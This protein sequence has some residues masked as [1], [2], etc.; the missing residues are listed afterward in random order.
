[1]MNRLVF[2]SGIWLA[3]FVSVNFASLDNIFSHETDLDKLLQM[4]NITVPN[5]DNSTVPNATTVSTTN[6]TETSTSPP[7]YTGKPNE[8]AAPQ[9]LCYISY[10]M[11]DNNLHQYIV[12]DAEELTRSELIRDPTVT[13][14]LYSDGS[15]LGDEIQGVLN[16]DGTPAAEDDGVRYM[17]WDHEKDS[18]VLDDTLGEL[19]SDN[20]NSHEEFL[21]AA[22][23]DCVSKGKEQYVLS[24]SSHGSG[25]SFGGDDVKER[26]RRKLL[27]NNQDIVSAV[28]NALQTVQGAPEKLDVIAFDS[29][30]QG[31]LESLKDYQSVTNY[32]MGSEALVPGT[33]KLI[34]LLF[35][36]ACQFS[37]C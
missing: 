4:D 27:A 17:T 11:S 5:A 3:N 28:S 20:P 9:A 34:L 7:K 10:Q 25:F 1:M 13:S 18:L 31:S 23:S 16:P 30:L 35:G 8:T 22:I 32:Y 15:P 36:G 24:F 33:G 21:I 37:K 19:D 29:C 26:R 14:W 12:A 2:L 6:M